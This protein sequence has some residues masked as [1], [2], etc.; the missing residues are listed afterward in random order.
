MFHDGFGQV[1]GD[2]H[3]QIAW[4]FERLA[5]GVACFRARASAAVSETVRACSTQ[6]GAYTTVM[7]LQW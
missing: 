7:D 2:K 3:V 1:P 4:G 5:V 6:P